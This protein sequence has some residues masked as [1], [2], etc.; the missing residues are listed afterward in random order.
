[1]IAFFNCLFLFPGIFPGCVPFFVLR[2]QRVICQ[3][4]E[5][6][7][8]PFCI[9]LLSFLP[10]V[11][12]DLLQFFSCELAVRR[13]ADALKVSRMAIFAPRM[14]QPGC[15]RRA[16]QRIRPVF[17]AFSA[18]YI[19]NQYFSYPGQA[20]R[21]GI[22][23]FVHDYRGDAPFLAH[24][25]FSLQ[26]CSLAGGTNRHIRIIGKRMPCTVLILDAVQTGRQRHAYAID[27]VRE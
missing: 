12:L 8:L 22:P 5:L 16:H 27:R 20:L 14:I 17:A 6:I 4:S 3:P 11:L 26:L 7:L 19:I 9:L 10:V 13:R 24:L 1:M 25:T 15:D 2:V 23:T 18:P 21:T